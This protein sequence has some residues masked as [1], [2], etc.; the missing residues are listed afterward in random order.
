[1]DPFYVAMS[2]YRQRSFNECARTCTE[3]LNNDSQHQAAW[4]LKLRALTQ[5]VAYDDTDVL[6]SLA[7]AS[8][9]ENQFTSTAPP[10]TSRNVANC[11]T[12]AGQQHQKR[13]P[14]PT[15][16]SSRPMSGVVRLNRSGLATGSQ[17]GQQQQQTAKTTRAQTGR[18][19]SR[20]G[21]ASVSS[22]DETFVINVARLNLTQYAAI[23]QLA[24]PLFEYL[25]F[26]QGNVKDV[27][28]F[29]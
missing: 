22:E 24:K 18:L 14:A 1:M 28:E 11:K 17:T 10:G 6:E 12:A 19:L 15:T 7:E 13:P 23:P 20:L 26:S 2:F 3:I 29:D 8:L 4:V 16:Q 25:Y 21:T 5:R 9:A 27:N